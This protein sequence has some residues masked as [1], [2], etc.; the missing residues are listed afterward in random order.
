VEHLCPRFGALKLSRRERLPNWSGVVFAGFGEKQIYPTLKEY[1]VDAVVDDDVRYC[2]NDGSSISYSHQSQVVPFAEEDTVRTLTE[3]VSPSFARKFY[4]EAVQMMSE[5]PGVVIDSI[6]ELSVAQKEQYKSQSANAG[7]SLF[8]DLLKNL[9]KYRRETFFDP[10]YQAIA[11]MPISELATVAEVFVNLSQI[12]QR[13][14]LET[15]TVGGPIDV[16][17]I[18]KGDGFVWIKR[19]HYF[20]LSMNPF[21][22]LKSTF[23]NVYMETVRER[24]R[25]AGMTARMPRGLD[26]EGFRP[27]DLRED[28]HPDAPPRREPSP[29]RGD[30]ARAALSRFRETLQEGLAKEREKAR[31]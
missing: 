13:M 24:A 30:A 6:T 4:E 21:F 16:A 8:K 14:S 15:E 25:R 19:K 18:S 1:I 9:N 2:F 11:M 28:R 5:L 26:P 31:V 22:V 29:R 27:D 10:I 12:R 20:D 23:R 17:V 3:G 7:V